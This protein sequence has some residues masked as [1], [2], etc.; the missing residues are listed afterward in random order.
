MNS[1]RARFGRVTEWLA[2]RKPDVV[3]VQE[4]KVE[5]AVFPGDDLRALGYESAIF[6]QKTYNGVAIL[7]RSE[8]QLTVTDVMRGFD[9]GVADEQARFIMATL[10]RKDAATK[11]RVA[12]AYIPNGQA[13]GSDKFHY[14]LAWLKRLR[15]FCDRQVQPD[16]SFVLCGDFNVAPDDRDVYDPVAWENQVLCHPDERQGLANVL[17]FGLED[18]FRKHHSESGVFSWWD[19]RQLAFPKNRGLRIDHLFGTASAARLCRDVV[20]DREARKGKEPSDHA[21]VIGTFDW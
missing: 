11:L 6:G 10:A 1:I 18:L 17:A 9:D 3:C 8:S 13:V 12:S 16:D 19:Y 7:T 5:D 21:P 2:S 14:K 20:I 15:A 4:T